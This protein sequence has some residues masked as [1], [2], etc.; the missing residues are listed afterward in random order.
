LTFKI[1]LHLF[2]TF[3]LDKLLN[4]FKHVKSEFHID[5]HLI[6]IIKVKFL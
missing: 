4:K 5:N 2:N 1:L 3:P 6:Q